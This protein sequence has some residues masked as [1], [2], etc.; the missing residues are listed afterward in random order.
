MD[1]SDNFFDRAIKWYFISR[2]LYACLGMAI[3]AV[4]GISLIVYWVFKEVSLELNYQHQYGADW[5]IEFEKYHGT[6][7]HAHTQMAICISSM[8]ALV[9][10]LIWFCRQTFHRH[11]Q[12][13]H[14]HHRHQPTGRD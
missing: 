6:V 5:Q 10:V 14:E 7:S 3:G 13:I 1:E 11:Q 9:A 8:L 4:A 12:H 2:F